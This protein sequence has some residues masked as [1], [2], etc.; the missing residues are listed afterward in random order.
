MYCQET[1][2]FL[3]PKKK[4]KNRTNN[5]FNDS[6]KQIRIQNFIDTHILLIFNNSMGYYITTLVGLATGV[7]PR[8]SR[9][10]RPRTSYL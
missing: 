9:G 5:P 3:Q 7:V 6:I 8:P 1:A 10:Q 4:H 2:K